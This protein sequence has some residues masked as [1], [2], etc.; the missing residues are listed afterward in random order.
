MADVLGERALRIDVHDRKAGSLELGD[1]IRARIDYSE[2]HADLG[3]FPVWRQRLAG[4]SV[5]RRADD[6]SL[7]HRVGVGLEVDLH[8]LEVITKRL[9]DALPVEP[10][11]EAGLR[12]EYRL[13]AEILPAL[14]F[15]GLLAPVPP[16]SIPSDRRT[17][18]ARARAFPA[19]KSL[20][21]PTR[22]WNCV[23]PM[24]AV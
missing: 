4:G 10:V 22:S 6:S 2:V 3:L 7:L 19:C 9:E 8:V 13:A 5:G 11:L 1:L 20:N 14:E 18:C 24:S 16:A 23:M 12:E 21:G 17:R 15:V